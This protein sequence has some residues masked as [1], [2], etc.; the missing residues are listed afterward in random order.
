MLF[1]RHFGRHNFRELAGQLIQMK[2]SFSELI[3]G[4]GVVKGKE[5]HVYGDGRRLES[6]W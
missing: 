1:G 6:G 3:E 4:G 2:S 5:G